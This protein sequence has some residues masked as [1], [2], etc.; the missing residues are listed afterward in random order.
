MFENTDPDTSILSISAHDADIGNPRPVVFSLVNENL[1][2]FRI[3]QSGNGKAE[4]YTTDIGLDRENEN[5]LENGGV[6]AFQVKATEVIDNSTFGDSSLSQIN[7]ILLDVDDHIPEFN[8]ENFK[9]TIP[10]NLKLDTP[11][12]GL[13]IFVNDKD[14]ANN[15]KYNLSLRNVWNSDGVFDVSPKRGEGR[16]PLVIKVKNPSRLDFDVDDE[17]LRKF[18]FEIVTLVDD[19]EMSSAHIE[20]E[21]EDSNDN[22]PIFPQSNYKL[23][24]EENSKI[25]FQIA[26]ISATDRDTGSFGELKYFIRGFGS[27]YFNTNTNSGGVYV[28]KNLDYEEQKSFSLSIVAVDGGGRESNA[29]LYINII[30]M[31]DNFPIFEST[32]YTRTIREGATLFEPQFFVRA[33]DIDGPSQGAGKVFYYIESENSI[34]GHVF[35]V[36]SETGEI[37]ITHPVSSMDTEK[38]QYELKVVAQDY[39]IPPLQNDTKVLIRVGISGNQRPIFK[40]HFSGVLHSALPGPPIYRVTISENAPP[41]YNVTK[42]E[43]TD[44]DGMDSFLRYRVQEASDNFI[45]DEITGL[46]TVSPQARLDRD[47]NEESYA[48]V[49][50]AV[51]GGYPIPETGINYKC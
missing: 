30:D 16:T 1:G 48:I 47:S 42:V 20:I 45:I 35:D 15:A 6:Y 34:S 11:L 17:L 24:V 22:S 3:E 38:G 49:V 28:N 50:N 40:G 37:K 13:N 39:G 41:G 4:L 12:P 26:E 7:I 44:P 31:N 29:N 27:E 32:E 23:Q 33:N 18:E 10:E 9:I 25:G 36:D 14:M 5:I 51:D 43:A 19:V 8:K 21:L 2:Y 46:I